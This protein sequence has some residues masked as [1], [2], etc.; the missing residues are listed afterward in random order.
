MQHSFHAGEWAPAL[1]ARV[2]V[3]KYKAGAAL[4]RNFYPDYRGGASSRPGTIYC[5]QAHN[6]IQPVRLIPFQA[7]FVVNFV[8]EFGHGYIRPMFNG[9]PLLEGA[10]SITNVTIDGAGVLITT[11]IASTVFNTQWVFITGV[12]GTTQLN[13]RYFSV[14][15]I[16]TTNNLI[17][18]GD[19]NYQ[20]LNPA[21]FSPYTGGGTIQAVFLIGSPY[22]GQDL[23]LLKFAQ[24]INTLVICHPSYAPRVLTIISQTNWTLAPLV[25]GATILAPTSVSV[26]TT[27][28]AGNVTYAY[29]V[30][31]VDINGQESGPSSPAGLSGVADIRSVAGTN[32]I[33]WAGSAGANSYNVYRA[34]V[35][36][37]AIPGGSEYGFIGSCNGTE[38]IDTNIGPDFSVSP[39]IVNNPFLGSGVQSLTLT[40][41]GAYTSIPTVTIDPPT[42]AGGVQA[43]AQALVE[44]DVSTMPVGSVGTFGGFANTTTTYQMVE[45]LTPP[46]PNQPHLG[47]LIYC[48]INVTAVDGNGQPS[49]FTV[50][51]V[52][53]SFGN[54][55]THLV[56]ND[57]VFGQPSGTTALHADT[58]GWHLK[59][60]NL[61]SGG[62]GYTTTPAVTVS[63]GPGTVTAVLAPSGGSGGSS[64]P[65]NPA[66]P[67]Y[68]QQRLVLASPINNPQQFNMSQPGAYFNFNK[69]DPIQADDAIQG[70]LVSSS[71]QSIKSMIGLS[72][73]LVMLSDKAAWLLNGGSAG[74]AIT[75]ATLV[76]NQHSYNGASDVPPIVV[77]FDILYVQSKGS[78]VRDLTYNFYASIYTGT[79]ISILSSHLFYGF[80]IKEWTYAEEPFKVVWAVRNDGQLLSLTYLK[81]QD[82]TGW[83]HHDSPAAGGLFKSVCSVTE[84]RPTTD[85][86]GQVNTV[87][88]TYFVVQRTV[89]GVTTQYIERLA[90]RNFIDPNTE[91][92][93]VKYAWCVD[94]GLQYFGAP[95]TM[96]S[97]L[98][99]LVGQSVVGLADGVPVGPLTVAAN[100]TVTIPVAASL[101]TLGLP[102]TAQLQTLQLDVGEPTIQGKRKKITAVTIRC[103]ET[104]NLQIGKTFSSSSLVS[105][106]DL[107]IGNVGTM[108]NKVVTDLVTA[109]ARTLIDPSWDVPGQYCIQQAQPLP[110]TILG[111][112]PELVVGDMPTK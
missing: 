70:T 57:F 31:A 55:P 91:L 83:S 8:L 23:A 74:S 96:V 54:L 93:T 89:N 12:S 81:E 39:P 27:L 102:F 104:L 100:G 84:S 44:I 87:D 20:L 30:T 59:G 41:N 106:K 85:G 21:L 73:G 56:S 4:M 24:N 90:E 38:F 25:F 19:L 95:I 13:G 33:S 51:P 63:P 77:N 112:I 78:V 58:V 75:P 61:I 5:I 69:S 53:V 88:A 16:D 62:S 72:T 86:R 47:S 18:L 94:S 80:T 32:L 98:N 64:V 46:L 10:F 67:T 34:Q 45:N 107:A 111:V 11:P 43:T 92:P 17:R 14:V 15:G 108:T 110:A 109:D 68:F 101:I 76:A 1:N 9:A 52:S 79:D 22:L 105:M 36:Y 71:L 6:A 48:T 40:A 66:V 42:T 82:I 28:S 29:E 99:H 35:S 65:S 50:H 3:A 26:S 49:A 60:V 37:T 7:N 103:Q 2:D 97:G